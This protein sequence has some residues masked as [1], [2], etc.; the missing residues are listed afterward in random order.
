MTPTVFPTEIS[1]TTGAAA[2]TIA[3]FSCDVAVTTSRA[4]TAI[5]A[6]TRRRTMR[7]EAR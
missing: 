1:G 4:S 3:V 2:A 7:R 5:T 6:T